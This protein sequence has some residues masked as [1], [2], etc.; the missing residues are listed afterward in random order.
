MYDVD[1]HSHVCVWNCNVKSIFFTEAEIQN[2]KMYMKGV[3]IMFYNKKIQELE[4]QKEIKIMENKLSTRNQI[5]KSQ[6]ELIIL[7]KDVQ[8]DMSNAISAYRRDIVQYQNNFDEISNILNSFESDSK[9]ICKI[10][11]LLNQIKKY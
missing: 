6:D 1:L 2:N 8:N 11:T 7:L 10:E 3:K 4:H 9:K 5:I